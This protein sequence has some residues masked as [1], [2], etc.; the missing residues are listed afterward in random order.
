MKN[1]TRALG[2]LRTGDRFSFEGEV[3]T[4]VV[5]DESHGLPAVKVMKDTG[6]RFEAIN[7]VSAS[8]RV[9]SISE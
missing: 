9:V 7:T 1:L 8:E 3:G 5:Y 2:E 4:W 6:E